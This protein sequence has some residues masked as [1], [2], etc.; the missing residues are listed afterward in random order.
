M[1]TPLIHVYSVI[2]APKAKFSMRKSRIRTNSSYARRKRKNV[3]LKKKIAAL[4]PTYK[5]TDAT[6]SLVSSILRR[7]KNVDVYL[8]D[9]CTPVDSKE[10]RT[11]EKIKGLANTHGRLNYH[12]TPTNNLKAAA[13]NYGI[14][15]IKKSTASYDVIVTFDDDVQIASSTLKSMVNKLYSDEKLGAVCSQTRVINKNKNLLTRLQALEYHGFTVTKTADNGLFKGPLVMQGMLTAFRKE[16]VDEVGGY[17][18]GHLIEDY[19]ITVRLKEHGWNVAIATD[20][21]AWTDVPETFVGLWKQRVRWAYGGLHV[22]KDH[23]KTVPAV[24]QDLLGHSLFISLTFFVIV[25]L[26]IGA[27]PS[28]PPAFLYSLIG[29]GIGQIIVSLFFNILTILS[30]EERD[31]IDWAIRLTLLPELLYSNILSLMLLGTYSYFFY[32]QTVG[33]IASKIDIASKPYRL[34]LYAFSKLG[35]SLTWGT[36][37]T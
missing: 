36:R 31:S 22:L 5:P 26:F 25:S 6:V 32:N 27:G 8:I 10:Y 18:E 30:Y 34:G 1:E 21:K 24:F 3:F 12:R 7:S 13:L 33:R 29:L 20:A 15:Q 35:Y 19:D 23:Y 2:A 14:K 9:D 4:I 28:L 37:T 11:I 16:A 17:T